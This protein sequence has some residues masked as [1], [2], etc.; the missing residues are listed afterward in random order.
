MLWLSGQQWAMLH[1]ELPYWQT[2]AIVALV[3]ISTATLRLYDDQHRL[4]AEKNKIEQNL[5]KASKTMELQAKKIMELERLSRPAVMNNYAEQYYVAY[6]LVE[7]EEYVEAVARAKNDLRSP[8]LPRYWQIKTCI[9][10]ARVT[11]DWDEAEV[12]T[13]PGVPSF[14]SILHQLSL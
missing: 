10:I 11:D 2:V 13:S 5:E 6:D 3:T 14:C 1:Q 7:Q 8:N 9:F 4:I 12:S